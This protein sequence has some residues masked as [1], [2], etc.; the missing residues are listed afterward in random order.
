MLD[1][2]L[3]EIIGQLRTL[4]ADHACVEAKR[5]QTKLPKSVRETLSA[6]AN[7]SGG[8][9]ILGLDEASGFH[10]TGVA[11][12]AKLAADL[13]ALCSENM[14]PP[15]RPL[16]QTHHFE[17]VALVVSEVAELD[18]ARK[19][20]HY[21]GASMAQGSFIRV[22]DGD[23]RLSPYEVH[24]MLA[25]RGQPHDDEQP[26]PGARLEHLDDALVERFLTRL[27]RRRSRAFA[28]LDTQAALR[29]AK[30]LI[31]GDVSLGGLLALGDYPQ[32]FFP[33]LMLTFVHYPM[34]T[35]PDP[36]SGARFID[37]VAAEGPIPVMV[38]EA[39]IA[40]RRNMSRRSTV[41]GVGRVDTW[42]YPERAL[43]EAIVNSLVH[44]D[45]SELSHGTQVQIEMYPD[46]LVIRNPGGLYG[47]VR[48]ENL[49]NEGTSSAR[50]A[51]LLKLLEDIPL[52][53]SDHPICENRGSGI[54]TMLAA[55]REARLSP[56][57]FMDNIATFTVTFPNHPLMAEEVINKSADATRSDRRRVDRR[58]ELLGA[59]GRKE[60]TRA[61]LSSLTGLPD[62]TVSRWINTLLKQGLVEATEKNLRSQNVR[63]RR[64]DKFSERCAQL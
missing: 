18:P 16:I 6:F 22:A 13:G 54:P 58:A 62:R 36:I 21:R 64:I 3:A 17:G 43:R 48:E 10:A 23:R 27:R 15:L 31:G 49:G 60:L 46:R 11:D 29:R 5:A 33:Q 1:N 7:T 39:L 57:R 14:E 40:L 2:E 61:E 50:N 56:P 25:N 45:Y 34:M 41:R 35:G 20:A 24:M 37:N 28:G 30:V 4:G 19:P 9:L 8:V 63:Y 12:P 52:P 47:S 38:D 53:G 51:T 26:V 42:E 44:R 59:L 32:E 55:L